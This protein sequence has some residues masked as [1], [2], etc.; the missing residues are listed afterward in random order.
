MSITGMAFTGISFDNQQPNV[1]QYLCPTTE[2][3]AIS[4]Q[5]IVVLG[6]AAMQSPSLD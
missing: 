4:V 2:P 5:R 6:H 3:A 1:K